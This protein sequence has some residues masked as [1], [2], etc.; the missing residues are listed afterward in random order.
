M[1]KKTYDFLKKTT[2]ILLIPT[3]TRTCEQYARVSD[4]FVEFGCRYALVCNGGLLL[5]DNIVDEKWMNETKEIAGKELKDLLEAE[6]V[7]HQMYPDQ[8]IHSANGIMVYFKTEIPASDADRLRAILNTN[9]LNIFL[10]VEKY[11]AF[12]HRSTREMQLNVFC[13]E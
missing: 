11:I 13:N 5:K 10:T 8:H 6:C 3:T 2:E 9:T 1:T 7:L 4:T 12:L